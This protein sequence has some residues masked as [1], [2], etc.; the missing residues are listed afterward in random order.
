MQDE[1]P[2]SLEQCLEDSLDGLNKV[3]W[4]RRLASIAEEHGQFQACGKRHFGAFVEAGDTLLVTFESLQG[5]QFNPDGGRPLGWDFVLDQGWSHLGLFSDG[6]TWFRDHNVYG[7]FDRLI[8][9]GFFEDFETVIFYGA[10]PAGYAAAAFS[11]SAPGARVVMV[12]PQATLDPRVTEW[13]DRFT[14]MRRI[15]FTDRY[16]YAPDMLDAAQHAYVLYDP[17]EDLDAMHAALFTRSNVTKL[18]MRFFGTALQ[19]DLQKLG[20]LAPLLEQ[21]AD[22]HLTKHSFAKLHRA[23]R[24]YGGY[25][26]NLLGALDSRDRP[27][28]AALL[29]RNVTD[30]MKVPRFR[31]RLDALKKLGAE[32]KAKL[33]PGL[34]ND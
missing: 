6:D 15:A 21:A 13:D 22:D 10:G 23:R 19:G 24:D 12:Q 26:R 30:R 4:I 27:Y 28:L 9:D 11:V 33:P 25:L 8:D 34:R 31:R 7:Y 14:H 29:C 32:G 17:S 3:E 5:A 1:G 16:G 20:L 18:R 2:R